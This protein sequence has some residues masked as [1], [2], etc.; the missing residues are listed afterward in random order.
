M[1]WC[2]KRTGSGATGTCMSDYLEGIQQDL[3][4]KEEKRRRQRMIEMVI[5]A[6]CDRGV[7]VPGV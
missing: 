5:L 1:R 7:R 2:R 6:R 3:D 4:R